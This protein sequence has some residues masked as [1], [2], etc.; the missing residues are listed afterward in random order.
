MSIEKFKETLSYEVDRN[1]PDYKAHVYEARIKL[2]V[3][4]AKIQTIIDT[5]DA[6]NIPTLK[7]LESEGYSLTEQG[8][9]NLLNY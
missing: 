3:E 6:A 5:F 2:Q 9:T 7:E 4:L 1:N 8:M